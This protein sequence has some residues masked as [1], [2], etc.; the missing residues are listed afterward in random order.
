MRFAGTGPMVSE[1]SWHPARNGTVTLLNN[2]MPAVDA[3]H[4]ILCEL[5]IDFNNQCGNSALANRLLSC[6]IGAT[7]RI[8]IDIVPGSTALRIR[9]NNAGNQDYNLPYKQKL[10]YLA[11]LIDRTN[12][13]Q[14][15]FNNGQIESNNALT[16]DPPLHTGAWILTF[17]AGAL[18]NA[19]DYVLMRFSTFIAIPG[20]INADVARMY[21]YPM[22]GL[23]ANLISVLGVIQSTFAFTNQILNSTTVLDEGSV[24]GQNLTA[25]A[26][27]Q[28][29]IKIYEKP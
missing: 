7:D 22:H 12:T 4:S 15:L 18:N 1:L 28:T 9:T 17:G 10:T 26:N 3:S 13:R 24:G 5:F 19:F 23:V 20:T 16:Q 29:Q 27:L 21:S 11:F 2:A 25:S 6:N 8:L 14:I